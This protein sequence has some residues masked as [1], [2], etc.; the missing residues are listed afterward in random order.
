MGYFHATKS[1]QLSRF[2]VSSFR[3]ASNRIKYEKNL[4]F[5]FKD[6]ITFQLNNSP[7]DQ[8]AKNDNNSDSFDLAAWFNPN[9][10]GGVIVW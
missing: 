7:S 1:Y 9:T 10:R 2:Q 4:Q 8:V 3:F 6:K 5:N